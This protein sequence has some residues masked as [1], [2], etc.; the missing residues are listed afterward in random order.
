[1]IE[2]NV[3]QINSLLLLRLRMRIIEYIYLYIDVLIYYYYYIINFDTIPIVVVLKYDMTW[4]LVGITQ[5]CQIHDFIGSSI[6]TI[7]KL[8]NIVNAK[9]I[10][11][12]TEQLLGSVIFEV[13]TFETSNIQ[14][15][16]QE[17]LKFSNIIIHI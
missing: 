1:M 4:Q 5:C 16:N 10:I 3:F 15:F 6:F 8:A 13:A 7:N 12:N 2:T 11:W 17:T 9:I 14:I